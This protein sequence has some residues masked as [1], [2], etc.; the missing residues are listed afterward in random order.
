MTDALRAQ[1]RAGAVAE[2]G[3]IQGGFFRTFV[4]DVDTM[5]R[6]VSAEA[7]EKKGV[8]AGDKAG[9][10]TAAAGRHQH[11]VEL[12]KH[13]GH[14]GWD[15]EA[16]TVL[17]FLRTLEKRKGKPA[18]A[19]RPREWLHLEYHACGQGSIHGGPVVGACAAQLLAMGGYTVRHKSAT[20]IGGTA[21][22][23]NCLVGWLDIDRKKHHHGGHAVVSPIALLTGSEL[24]AHNLLWGLRGFECDSCVRDHDG[25]TGDPTTARKF[26]DKPMSWRRCMECLHALLRTPAI[27]SRSDLTTE[28]VKPPTF[29]PGRLESLEPHSLK[30]VMAEMG[31]AAGLPHQIVEAGAWAG[32]D[33]ENMSIRDMGAA[34]HRAH[35]QSDSGFNTA[36]WY[37][38]DGMKVSGPELKCFL[39]TQ[40]RYGIAL[41]GGLGYVRSYHEW[42]NILS[43]AWKMQQPAPATR[44]IGE[45]ET[46][47]NPSATI[48]EDPVELHSSESDEPAP[49][50]PA[51]AAL[52]EPKKPRA[53]RARTGK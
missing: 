47:M 41:L 30:H 16:D 38:Q 24:W 18:P 32:S 19:L 26:L 13:A 15:V 28:T 52:P 2:G 36:M 6:W 23:A 44:P 40:A 27:V 17:S 5:A 37:G 3:E 46:T 25:E 34:A 51:A 14:S 7:D 11:L 21:I 45:P 43:P 48:E 49:A 12:K 22:T 10:C 39:F 29:E 50:A 20:Q 8:T 31:T 35:R 9:G 42:S 33:A 53:K 4:E 1:G